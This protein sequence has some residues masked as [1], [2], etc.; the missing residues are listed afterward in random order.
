MSIFLGDELEAIVHAIIGNEEFTPS[1]AVRMDL[2]TDVLPTFIKDNTDRNRTSPFAFTGNKFEF[3]MPGSSV[4]LADANMVLNTIIAKTL[5]DFAQA[6][7][8]EKD[9]DKAA[10]R[11]MKKVLTDHERI[12]FNGDNY[13]AEW[14]PEAARRGLLNLR[15]TPDALPQYVTDEAFA[16]FEEFGV[17]S[18]VEVESRYEVKL[19]Y[20]AKKVNIEG[21]TTARLA[22]R[23]YLPAIIEFSA[24]IAQAVEVKVAAGSAGTAAEAELLEK[25]NACIDAVYAGVEALEEK[26]EA[27]ALIADSLEKAQAYCYEVIPAMDAVRAAVDVA[28]LLVGDE[29]WPV[30]TY[31][32]MLFY[33]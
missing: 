10:R 22:R 33:T 9:F 5:S 18:R 24:V 23:Q 14:P 16:L 15:S 25:L 3:R 28:E 20:Y 29:Y 11:Y 32:E 30:P 13:S 4:N 12:I 31:N 6:V 2:G 19:G 17:L 1:G 8:G 26:I 7:E 27:A 21:L